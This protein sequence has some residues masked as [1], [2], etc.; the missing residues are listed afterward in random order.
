MERRILVGS[1]LCQD[2]F[3][4][5]TANWRIR[6]FAL[7]V[8]YVGANQPASSGDEVESYSTLCGTGY[9]SGNFR[10][11]QVFD[12][13]IADDTHRN[14]PQQH[15]SKFAQNIA[16]LGY[17]VTKQATNVDIGHHPQRLT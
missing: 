3:A 9:K 11:A 6:L 4:Q 17:A 2:L 14:Q 13:L 15:V 5:R 16:D 7:G 10:L 12:E 8:V 1:R